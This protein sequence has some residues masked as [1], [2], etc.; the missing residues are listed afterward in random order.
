MML[1]R[2]AA[3]APVPPPASPGPG[4]GP[5]LFSLPRPSSLPG[6]G[7]SLPR[8][9]TLLPAPALLSPGLSLPRPSPCPGHA[10]R[11]GRGRERGGA[12]PA[13]PLSLP[14]PSLKA[15]PA[16]PRAFAADG[17]RRGGDRDE[18]ERAAL[19]IQR[20]LRG[21][22]VRK[23]H[24]WRRRRPASMKEEEAA[25]SSAIAP[26]RPAAEHRKFLRHTAVLHGRVE[27]V[28]PGTVRVSGRAEL[29]PYDFLV[30]ATGVSYSGWKAEE[31]TADERVVALRG[32]RDRLRSARRVLI[33]GGGPTGVEAAAEILMAAPKR[34]VTLVHSGPALLDEL[35]SEKISRHAHEFL[36][37][38]GANILLNDRVEGVSPGIFFGTEERRTRRVWAAARVLS[39]PLPSSPSI[40]SG[41]VVAAD[42]A[43]VAVGGGR[44]NAA[45]LA[46]AFLTALD[47]SG[48]VRVDATLR[49]VGTTNVFSAG[50]V[51][52]APGRKGA[53]AAGL[54]AAVIAENI[55]RLA[56]NPQASLKEFS[57]AP[58]ICLVTLGAGDGGLATPWFGLT[59]WLPKK[60]KAEDMFVPRTR[61]ELGLDQKGCAC[62]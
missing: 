47:G 38:H 5:A 3:V 39:Y 46:R 50:D 41:A 45:F 42:A 4:P 19:T 43:L 25:A 55:R 58:P 16:L 56:V 33:V 8:P 48:F 61:S 35:G 49:V 20:H 7:L 26:A 53:Y 60:M 10:L 52:T 37:R 17:P 51:C 6:P 36:A 13:P 30:V 28:I 34:E 62:L 40:T 22:Q 32:M 59:G 24:G 31:A 27:E 11:E 23:K 18:V 57:P 2:A 21:Y 14:R 1:G 29:V 44:P 15:S 54:H 12:A 9:R